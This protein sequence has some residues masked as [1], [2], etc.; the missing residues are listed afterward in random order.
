MQPGT[1]RSQIGAV[2]T[3]AVAEAIVEGLRLALG[4]SWDEG[5][6]RSGELAEADWLE[7]ER[8]GKDEWTWEK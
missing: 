8:Y 4:G 5:D 3:H 2:G 7:K 1:L 6:Y